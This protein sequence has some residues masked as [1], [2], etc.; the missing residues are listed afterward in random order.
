MLSLIYEHVHP[1]FEQL[2]PQ[3]VVITNAH[4]LDKQTIELLLELRRPTRRGYSLIPRCALILCAQTP[5]G[6]DTDSQWSKLLNTVS[7][8][9]AAWPNHLQYNSLTVNEFGIVMLTIVEE[10]LNAKFASGLDPQTT[11]QLFGKWTHAN[12]WLIEQLIIKLDTALGSMQQGKPRLV[13]QAV[14][15][16]VQK[17]WLERSQQTFESIRS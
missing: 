14:V 15:E 1:L 12:W 7:E 16:Q 3:A 4:L 9:R 8:T 2:Q 10:N 6:N 11:L 5:L 13:T 17:V